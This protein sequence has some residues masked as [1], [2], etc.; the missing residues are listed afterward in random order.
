MS[1]RSTVNQFFYN[2]VTY[3]K[4]YR[5]EEITYVKFNVMTSFQMHYTSHQLLNL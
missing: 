5:F 3:L 2:K 1:V 4:Q